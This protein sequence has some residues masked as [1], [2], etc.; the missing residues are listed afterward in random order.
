MAEMIPDIYDKNCS[1]AEK[2]VFNWFK[3]DPLTSDWVVLHSLSLDSHISLI[4]GEADFVVLAPKYGVFVD[5]IAQIRYNLPVIN[6][7]KRAA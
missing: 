2:K 4:N 3:N 5:N 6:D 1:D 7:K